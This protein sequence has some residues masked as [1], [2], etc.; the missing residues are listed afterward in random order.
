MFDVP[1]APA[2]VVLFVDAGAAW[3]SGQSVNWISE[4]D[5]IERLQVVSAGL[6]ARTLLLGAFPL[7]FYY[8]HPFQRPEEDAVLGFRIGVGW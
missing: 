8:A 7:E 1:A 4:R 6:A 2:E 3:S 5:T